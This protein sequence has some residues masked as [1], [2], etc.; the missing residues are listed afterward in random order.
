MYV[1]LL[2]NFGSH[3]DNYR[4]EDKKLSLAQLVGGVDIQPPSPKFST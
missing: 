2:Q 1:S 4:A 3:W